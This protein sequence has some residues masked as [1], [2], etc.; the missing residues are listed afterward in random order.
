MSE[1][2]QFV[3]IDGINDARSLVYSTW[4]RSYQQSGPSV[5]KVSRTDFFAGHHKVLDG[6]FA[7]DPVVKLAVFPDDPTVVFG[8]SVTEGNAVHYVYVKPDFRR[9][10]V[11]T[12]LLSHINRPFSYSHYT[13]VLRDLDKHLNGCSHNPYLVTA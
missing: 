9:F 2:Q 5:R 1:A 13:Y 6:I 3:V 8:W 10:G 7:R 11:A 4:L 12:A